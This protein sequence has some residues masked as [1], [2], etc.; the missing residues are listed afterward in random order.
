MRYKRDKE[1]K[2]DVISLRLNEERIEVLERHRQTLMEQLNR[3]V[4]LSEAA[5]LVL[6]DRVETVE[7]ET[8]RYKLL[9]NPAESLWKIR[10]QW[11]AEHTLS[12][13]EWEMVAIYLQIGAEEQRQVPP[14]WRPAAP[15][16]ESFLGLVGAFQ[17]L[18][19]NQKKETFGKHLWYYFANL[20]GHHS[21][22][23]FVETD[24]V[25]Q[26]HQAVLRLIAKQKEQLQSEADWQYPGSVGRCLL[27]AIQSEYESR[28]IDQALAPYWDLL[29]RIAARGHWIRHH[30]PVRVAQA[31]SST[32]PEPRRFPAGIETRNVRLS[33]GDGGGEDIA[34]YLEFRPPRNFIYTILHYPQLVEF[35]AML[36]EFGDLPAWNGRYFRAVVTTSEDTGETKYTLWPKQQDM[37]IGFTDKEWLRLRDLFRQ[38]WEKPEIT[39]R[40]AALQLEYGEQG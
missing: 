11:E 1:R 39:E 24:E 18:L 6:E 10:Q 21:G 28:R 32:P 15:C 20:D 8:A 9:K 34:F 19:Q 30:S 37:E 36:E 40:M 7:R 2:N 5:F 25:E 22:I 33:F 31:D 35:H 4:S 38:A 16:R 12:V 29:W 3:P 23:P 13:A 14:V 26:R 17:S 27:T